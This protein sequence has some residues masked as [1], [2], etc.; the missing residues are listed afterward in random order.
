MLA[1]DYRGPYRVRAKHKPDPAIEHPGDA[2]VRVTRSCI[3]GSDLHLYHG[4]VP[5]TRIGSTAGP[6]LIRSLTDLAA[7]LDGIGG[8]LLVGALGMALVWIAGAVF[9]LLWGVVLVS[10]AS[11]I[12]ASG[13]SLFPH[14]DY[15]R[16][17]AADMRGE[18]VPSTF[19]GLTLANGRSPANGHVDSGDLF[20]AR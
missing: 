10:F 7:E 11:A 4:L 1:M 8:A 2:I 19:R 6:E 20:E 15:Q 3:C 9:G 16:V 13:K 5:D 12:G 17:D 18:G 14:L